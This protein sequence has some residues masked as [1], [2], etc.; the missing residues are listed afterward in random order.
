M[1]QAGVDHVMRLFMRHY[2][3]GTVQAVPETGNESR[4]EDQIGAALDLICDEEMIEK[5]VR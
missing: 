1:E 2:T 5:A 4:F 3:D